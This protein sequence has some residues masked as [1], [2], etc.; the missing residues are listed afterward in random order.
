MATV[1]VGIIGLGFMGST[2][3]QIYQGMRGA[4]IVA[5]ADADPAKRK[6]DVSSVISNIGG[7]GQFQTPR[8]DGSQCL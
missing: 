3:W 8:H 5:L 7:G 1:K 2:H 4:K 6:G